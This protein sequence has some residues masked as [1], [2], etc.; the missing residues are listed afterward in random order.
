[1]ASHEPP[2]SRS[3]AFEESENVGRNDSANPTMGESLPPDTT[4]AIC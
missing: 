4:V 3:Q 2:M 1:M